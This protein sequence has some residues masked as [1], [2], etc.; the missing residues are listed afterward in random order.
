MKGEGRKGKEREVKRWER[1]E[2]E[3]TVKGKGKEWEEKGKGKEQN[4]KIRPVWG[5]DVDSSQ[6]T[7]RANFKVTLHKN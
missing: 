3:R 6:W 7:D 5:L 4:K 1:I 2:K